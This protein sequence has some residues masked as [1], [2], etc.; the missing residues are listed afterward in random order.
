MDF[1]LSATYL[2]NFHQQT[3]GTAMGSPLSVTVADLV[4][5]DV[6]IS[7]YVI[8]PIFWKRYVDDI[9]TVLLSSQIKPFMD[10]LNSIDQFHF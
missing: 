1:C 4:M 7:S 5:E 3:F 8:P 6:A 9:C 2:D 10:H